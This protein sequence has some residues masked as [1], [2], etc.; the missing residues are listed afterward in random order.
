MRQLLEHFLN[1]CLICLDSFRLALRVAGLPFSAKAARRSSRS[2]TLSRLADRSSGGR[3]RWPIALLTAAL[4]LAGCASPSV[5]LPTPTATTDV[6]A[7][8]PA[9]PTG[10]TPPP[11]ASPAEPIASPTPAAPVTISINLG[12]TPQTLDPAAVAP[13]DA[14]ANDLVE[15]LFAGLGYLNPTT[16]RVEPSLA[17]SW[18]PSDG[19]RTWRVTLRGDAQ[20]VRVDAS[21]GEV[22]A[23]RPI[24]PRDVITAAKRACQ[25]GAG[26]ALGR[27]PSLFSISGCRD[28]YE[29]PATA[30]D[31]ALGVRALDDTT[32]EFELTAESGLFPTLLTLPS[33]RP[34][35]TDLITEAGD[36]WTQPESI[37]TSGPYTL[38]PAARADGGYTL[39]ANPFWPLPR[40][41]NVDRI[42]ATF[43][44]GSDALR[45]WQ[46]GDLALATVPGE[47]LSGAASTAPASPMLDDPV[48]HLLALPAADLMSAQYDVPPMDNPGVRRA[49]SLSLD[50]ESIARIL[51]VMGQPSLPATT[52]TPPGA[53]LSPSYGTAG[54]EYDPDA[55]LRE[56]ADA[57][58]RDCQL[59]PPVEIVIP[60]G[61]AR[62]EQ[63]VD[64]A[65]AGW[66][67]TLGCRDRFSIRRR[68]LIEVLARFEDIPTNSY[69]IPRP[70]LI[71]FSWLG[72]TPDAQ[73][74]Q[75][76]LLGCR[77]L[78]PGS[79]LNQDRACID[80]ESDL[81]DALSL[82]DQDARA[83][84]YA[85]VAAAFFGPA[86][87][88]PAIP[89][90]Y[91]ARALVVQPWLE[92]PPQ[93]GG[94]LRFDGWLAHSP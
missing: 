92:I 77:E 52:I 14:S 8:S 64:L 81:S 6:A 74:W 42:E 44:G 56:L 68:P 47:S 36:A 40:T 90:T 33:L 73:H 17:A 31:D 38:W 48:V 55:A 11:S 53:A 26:A 1:D 80:A 15:N 59:M 87:E 75:A 50:R 3:I 13:L 46:D 25:N 37:Q 78:F 45:A 18:E 16:G 43:G 93:D 22:I 29:T 79:F 19:G 24:E 66:S 32:V 94:P 58:Y 10:E 67:E 5:P 20:W 88:M 86:G 9:N 61:D 23:V 89:V 21:T 35:P 39:I 30:A 70:G 76:D 91:H 69:Q 71:I 85:E 60:E 51:T 84:V 41:G 28:L 27:D 57:G 62:A 12:A 63:I 7:P 65:I 34:V 49:L 83:A 2:Q 4:L 54:T 72:D 82:T